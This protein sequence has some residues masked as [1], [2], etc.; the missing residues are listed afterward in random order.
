MAMNE[1]AGSTSCYN[2]SNVVAGSAV[3]S[4]NAETPALPSRAA[5]RLNSAPHGRQRVIH[6]AHTSKGGVPTHVFQELYGST[7]A[8]VSHW[9]TTE[10]SV[11]ALLGSVA[12]IR[13]FT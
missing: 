11:H 13:N 4:P 9:R 10:A 1:N 5:R 12:G 7:T 6:H 3:K 8:D 2:H